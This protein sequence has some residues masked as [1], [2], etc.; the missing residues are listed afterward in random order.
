MRW[1]SAWTRRAKSRRWTAHRRR[2]CGL[3]GTHDYKRHGTTSLFA[4]LELKTNRV[5]GQLHRRHR[6]REFRQFPDT[7]ESNVPAE[8]DV[9]IVGDNYGTHKTA[10]VRRW[11]AQR[12]RFHVHFTPT[13]GSWINPV[14][15]WFAEITNQRI[16]RGVF[17]SVK[18]LEGAIR[19][20]IAV[21]NQ[22]PKPFVWTRTADQILASIAR[23]VQRTAAAQPS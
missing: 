3:R 15:R 22:D 7:I 14:E 6:S 10:I 5:I 8:F 17:R 2:L 21:H 1:C 19:E 12:P 20:Y 9:H 18:E 13:Y 11:F 16:R 23:Y 4:A